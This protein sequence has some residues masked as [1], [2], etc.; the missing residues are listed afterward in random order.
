MKKVNKS[1][2]LAGPMEHA[3]DEGLQWR[4]T[5]DRVLKK[6]FG[7]KCIIPNDEEKK[8]K[9]KV[10][11]REAKK[12]DLPKY[13]RIMREFIRQDLEFIENVDMLIT[14]WDGEMSA[15]TMGE[16]T[17]AYKIGKPNYLVTSKKPVDIPGWFLACFTEIFSSLDELVAYFE[18]H[19]E[20]E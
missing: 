19:L 5:F 7:I 10:S 11:M 1:G 12:T 8:I 16:A 6:K 3:A 15:G 20:E 17:Y 4:R 2:Y 13:I 18:D 14:K 9:K